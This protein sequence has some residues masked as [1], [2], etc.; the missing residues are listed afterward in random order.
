MSNERVN[1]FGNERIRSI[2]ENMLLE[3]FQ[4]EYECLF[5]D[6]STAWITWDEIKAIHC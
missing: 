6:E 1:L 2:F 5:I 4:A 3:D